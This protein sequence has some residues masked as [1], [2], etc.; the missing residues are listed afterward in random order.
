M[1]DTS[2]NKN[3]RVNQVSSG[4]HIVRAGINLID[5]LFGD[6]QMKKILLTQGKFALVD[7]ADYELLNQWK[8]FTVKRKNK[9]SSEGRI[10]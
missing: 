10:R 3:I 4:Q 5:F 8:W 2:V 1:N 9:T 7:D 6:C